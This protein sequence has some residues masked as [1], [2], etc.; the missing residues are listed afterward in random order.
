MTNLRE[1]LDRLHVSNG[2]LFRFAA[3]EHW[4]EVSAVWAE[5]ERARDRAEAAEEKHQILLGVHK[6][7][8]AEQD[9]TMEALLAAEAEN[10][11]LKDIL[12]NDWNDENDRL[13]E[14]IRGLEAE[15]KALREALESVWLHHG[16]TPPDGCQLCSERCEAALAASGQE[17]PGGWQ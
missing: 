12:N 14:R 10:R 16:R 13:R 7:L 17:D 2:A 6:L 15:N 9:K 5:A 1:E 11:R 3:D 8:Q 4:S